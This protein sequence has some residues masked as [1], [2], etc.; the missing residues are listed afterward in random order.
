[1]VMRILAAFLALL[2]ISHAKAEVYIENMTSPEVSAAIRAGR[3]VAIIYAGSTEQNGP[4]M[5]LGKHNVMAHRL[6]GM[7]AEKLGNALVYP[8]LPFAPTGDPSRRSG[9]MRYPGSV[10]LRADVYGAVI[11]DVALSAMA[12]GFKYVLIMGDHGEGQD[13]LEKVARA[14]DKETRPYGVRVFHVGSVYEATPGGHAGREDTSMLM[15]A[16]GSG[17]RMDKIDEAGPANGADSSPKG[18][19]IE[20]GE[21]LSESRVN[22]AVKEIRGL[23]AAH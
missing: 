5:V 21:M 2:F 16:D 20:E 12:S 23:T 19:S 13:M 7:I 18:A 15:A 17:V 11:E 3:N 22:A 9:H 6:A 1:M 10:S 8:V 14:L 4:H